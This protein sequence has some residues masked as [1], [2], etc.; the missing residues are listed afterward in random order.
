MQFKKLQDQKLALYACQR[1]I[2][3]YFT[4]KTWLW[5]QIWGTHIRGDRVCFGKGG[6]S[7]V[8]YWLKGEYKG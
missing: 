2:R 1:A 3:N 8:K 7:N 6:G 5:M 4:S